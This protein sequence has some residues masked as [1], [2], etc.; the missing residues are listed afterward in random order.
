MR[1]VGQ[2]FELTIPLGETS[3]DTEQAAALRERFHAEHERVYGF[4]APAEPVELVS[5]RLTTVGRIEKPPLAPSAPASGPL[6]PKEHRQVFFAETGGFVDCP[7]HDRYALG[8]GASFA[9]PAV[10]EELDSTVVVHPGYGV[11]VDAV[12]NLVIRKEPA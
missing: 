3:F 10:V 5:L 1:Y 2:S 12:G 11:A 8:A 4:N 9:G 6:R 7:I